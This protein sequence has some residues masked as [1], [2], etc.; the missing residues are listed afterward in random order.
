MVKK[1]KKS[2]SPAKVTQDDI[3]TDKQDVKE[4]FVHVSF[5]FILKYLLSL[6]ILLHQYIFLPRNIKLVKT[7]T[8]GH[9]IY[10]LWKWN[11]DTTWT[12]GRVRGGFL[13]IRR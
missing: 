7:W 8:C 11:L 3:L 2:P 4:H 1:K 9:N 12:G 10:W 6:R 5:H 13:T